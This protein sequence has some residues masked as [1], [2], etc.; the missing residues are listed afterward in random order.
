[1]R[2]GDARRDEV[3]RAGLGE[4]DAAAGVHAER[5]VPLLRRHLEERRRGE[6][7]GGADE[8]VEPAVPLDDLGDERVGPLD[9]ARSAGCAD[10]ASPSRATAAS[11]SPSGRSTHATRAPAAT[12][13]SAH[14]KPIPRC[15]PVTRD[16]TVEP[17][18]RSAHASAITASTST[19]MSNGRCGTPIDVRAASRS[20]P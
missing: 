8:D 6:R 14:A 16:A 7:A 5:A 15:A 11:S 13:A 19:G 17:P 1:M 18:P 10:A 2:P 20:G 9:L 3:T 12:N 4:E